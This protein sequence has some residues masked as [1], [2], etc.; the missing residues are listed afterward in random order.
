MEHAFSY[1]PQMVIAHFMGF[2]AV[3][4]DGV[5]GAPVAGFLPDL[6][7]ILTDILI[8]RLR[9]VGLLLNLLSGVFLT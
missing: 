9:P 5:R 2:G 7:S 1:K 6:L 3:A 4:R 8:P